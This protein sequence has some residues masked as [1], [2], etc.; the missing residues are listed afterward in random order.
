MA[1][2]RGDFI[3]SGLLDEEKARLLAENAKE[4]RE[5]AEAVRGR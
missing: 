5:A 2:N 3:L 4:Q 1:S